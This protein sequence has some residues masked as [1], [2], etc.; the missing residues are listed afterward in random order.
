MS[1]LFLPVL[2]MG[3]RLFH[4]P[5]YGFG[6]CFFEGASYVVFENVP[7]YPPFFSPMALYSDLVRYACSVL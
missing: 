3:Q 6:S 5:S 2:P 1:F 4:F 7:L